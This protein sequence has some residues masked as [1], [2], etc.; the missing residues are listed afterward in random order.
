[1]LSLGPFFAGSQYGRNSEPFPC[2]A[3]L[4]KQWLFEKEVDCLTQAAL[5]AL[6]NQ[7]NPS[8]LLPR[9]SAAYPCLLDFAICSKK[10]LKHLAVGFFV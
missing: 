8:V 1:L 4:V 6:Q 10:Y 2:L 5:D 9:E 7:P 3:I